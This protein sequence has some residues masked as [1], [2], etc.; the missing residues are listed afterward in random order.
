MLVLASVASAQTPSKTQ[1]I[2]GGTGQDSTGWSGCAK[3]TAGVW[4]YASCPVTKTAVSHQWLTS[5]DASTGTFGQTRPACG[6]LSDSST[7]CTTTVGTAATHAATDFLPSTTILPATLALVTHKYFTS[8]DSTTGL[9]TAAQPACGDLSDSGTACTAASSSF[10]P[11]S[12]VLPAT[13]TGVAGSP[14]LSYNAATGLFTQGALTAAQVGALPSTTVLASS[15]V[16]ASHKWVNSYDATTGLFTNTQPACGDLSDSGTACTA[17]SSSFLSSSTVLPSTKALVTHNFFTSYTSGTGLFTAA[18]PAC[19]DL[20]DSGTAC[21]AA[22]SSFLSSSTVLPATKTAVAGSPL[23]SYDATTGAFTQGTLTAAQVSALPASTVLPSS[24]ASAAH[25]FLTSYTSGTGAF[26][27]AQPVC[28][29]LSD[30]GTACTAA[31][32]SFL[33]SGTVLPANTTSTTHQWFNAYNSSTG[34]FTKAQPAC[35][36]LSDSGTGCSS[37]TSASV[38]GLRKSSGAGSTDVA[39]TDG[40]DYFSSAQSFPNA[41]LTNGINNG[42]ASSAQSQVVVSGTAYY[43]T[44]SALTMPAS[45]KT[46]GG[47]STTTRFVWRVAMTKTAAGTGT[48]QIAIYR[49]TNGSTSDTQ[50]VLQTIGTQTAA[51]DNMTVDVQLTVTATGGTGSYFWSIIPLNKAASATGFGV[52][53]GAGA[54]FSGTKSS[55]AMNTASLKFGLGFVATTGTPTIVIPFVNAQAFNMN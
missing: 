1:P 23:L 18:Q 29:D 8:Y 55:V 28:G 24:I 49:G 11:S 37:A 17:A 54:F 40:T 44:N 35:G 46:N 10:L 7:G 20:S 52:T 39:A 16:S 47:M 14:L 38:T 19:S 30:A 9:F 12:T 5:F 53:T 43:I 50:D 32:S 26:T 34:A 45:S 22:S 15:I 51:A 31:S 41:N 48:F 2:N 36:D 21:T 25:N 3:V 4:S 33:S 13:K 42:T 27:K 6:D